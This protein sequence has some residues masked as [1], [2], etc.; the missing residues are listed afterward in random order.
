MVNGQHALTLLFSSNSG[1]WSAIIRSATWSRWSHVA[2]VSGF[3]V[4]EAVTSGVRRRPTMAAIHAARDASFVDL[5]CADPQSIVDAAESQ[6][7]KPYDWTALLGIGLH[8]NWQDD[9]AWFCSELVAWSFA[10]AGQPLFRKEVMR[11]VTPEHLWMLAP[12]WII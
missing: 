12:K 9:D 3:H 4:I 6:I 10:A 5:P 8:R 2:I 1:P 7:G 11:R